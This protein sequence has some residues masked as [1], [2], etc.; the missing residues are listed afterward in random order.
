MAEKFNAKN[1][2]YNSALPPFLAALRAQNPSLGSGAA[3][4]LL[5]ANR[6]HRAKRSGSAEAEDGPVV[7][8]AEGNVVE[9]KLEGDGTVRYEGGAEG[10]EDEGEESDGGKKA[11]KTGLV[12]RKRKARVVGAGQEEDDE[13]AAKKSGKRADGDKVEKVKNEK[14]DKDEEAA[15]ESTSQSKKRVKGKKAKKIKLS[16]DEET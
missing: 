13:P 15:D 6:R 3:D 5:A 8:D 1:L 14:R 10:G 16:F 2:S 4:P 12:G 11:E 9:A 7:V